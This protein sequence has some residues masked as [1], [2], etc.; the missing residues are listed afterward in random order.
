MFLAPGSPQATMITSMLGL[1]MREVLFSPTDRELRARASF[2]IH[3]PVWTKRKGQDH[4]ARRNEQTTGEPGHLGY[5]SKSE[6]RL[7]QPGWL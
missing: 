3:F 2:T 1:R 7:N 4:S 5:F 6:K